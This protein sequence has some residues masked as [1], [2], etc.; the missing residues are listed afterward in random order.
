MSNNITGIHP[1]KCA[2][3]IVLAMV[4]LGWN[5]EA[6][7]VSR[8]IFVNNDTLVGHLVYRI[9]QGFTALSLLRT[10]LASFPAYGSSPLKAEYIRPDR[11]FL[12]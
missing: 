2:T 1:A 3:T 7:F 11:S 9:G 10:G 12:Y 4:M 6:S 5:A 8:D